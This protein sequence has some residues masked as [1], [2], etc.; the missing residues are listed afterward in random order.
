MRADWSE[1]ASAPEV[2]EELIGADEEF[3]FGSPCMANREIPMSNSETE[4]HPKHGH[5]RIDFHVAI[6]GASYAG[7]SFANMLH[8]NSIPFTIFD[9]SRPVTYIMGGNDFNIPSFSAV[10]ERL[11]LKN[12]ANDGSMRNPTRKDVIDLLLERVKKNIMPEHCLIK[13]I[14]E[15]SSD[16]HILTE[17]KS[18]DPAKRRRENIQG[19]YQCIV[20]ADGVLSLCRS[21]AFR[22]I[23]LVGDARWAND[24]WYDLGLQRIKR[25]AD[26][27][28]MD[29]V[30]LGN[31]SQQDHA[32]N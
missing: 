13:I 1:N 32:P 6:I 28:I 30:T 11:D 23:F 21:S 29:G 7:L 12:F 3:D 9:R 14:R 8:L 2:D 5:G 10:V 22:G 27:A 24:R 31:L 17:T 19:P 4:T 26:I 18:N 20:R 15:G 16:F 25:G